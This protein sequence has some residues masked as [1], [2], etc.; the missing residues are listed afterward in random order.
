[1]S[2]IY[3]RYRQPEARKNLGSDKCRWNFHFVSFNIEKYMTPEFLFNVIGIK[4][5]NS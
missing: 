2:I 1:M 3:S 5:E 4:A